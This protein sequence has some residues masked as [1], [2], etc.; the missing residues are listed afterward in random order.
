MYV[1]LE[2]LPPA[3][4]LQS[5]R[6]EFMQA[7]TLTLEDFYH[8]GPLIVVPESDRGYMPVKDESGAWLDVN[9]WR[10]YF[11]PGYKR[12]NAELFVKVGEWLEDRFPGAKVYYGHDVDDQNVT[13]FDLA[14]RNE[15]L[16]LYHASLGIEIKISESDRARPARVLR[17]TDEWLKDPFN[18]SFMFQ[19]PMA[20]LEQF[21]SGGE[22]HVGKV[23][24]SLTALSTWYGSKGIIETSTA[25]S[26]E[27]LCWSFWFDSFYNTIMR[28]SFEQGKKKKP[29][30]L[31]RLLGQK[32]VD[33]PRISFHEEGLLLAKAFA[34]GLVEQG[35]AIGRDSFVG[36][37]EG[38]F[39]ATNQTTLTPFL[40]KC[41]ATWKNLTLPSE[42]SFVLVAPYEELVQELTSGPDEIR[43]ALVKACDYHLYRSKDDTDDESYEFSNP[44]YAVYPVEILF[45]LRIRQ[46]LGLT[47]PE[48]DHPLLDSPLGKLPSSSCSMDPSLDPI[49]ERIKRDFPTPDLSHEDAHKA[50]RPDF[51]L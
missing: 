16:D 20:I 46:I 36:L 25:K 44:V 39:Y 43:A 8:T 2:K 32:H 19:E 33:K 30:L 49:R 18:E 41:F 47:N 51:V 6:E 3:D 37:T 4:E 1:S 14:A 12:G 42:F 13:Q 15:L 48:V 5:L 21:A 35:E 31:G 50:Q 34:L 9:L 17:E 26:S 38:W 27:Q 22:F 40:L 10:S 24:T 7:M 11:G 23:L 28:S 45:F 29:P